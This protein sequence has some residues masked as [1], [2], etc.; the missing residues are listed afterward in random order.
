M[1]VASKS[2]KDPPSAWGRLH[3]QSSLKCC[4]LEFD[5][6]SWSYYKDENI[7]VCNGFFSVGTA[8]LALSDWGPS[9]WLG[10]L[11]ADQAC[12]CSANFGYGI[13][14]LNSFCWLKLPNTLNCFNTKMLIV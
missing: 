9:L 6:K 13:I 7:S 8:N 3:S 11:T 10:L 5:L 4:F 14:N 1:C 12:Y 2:S